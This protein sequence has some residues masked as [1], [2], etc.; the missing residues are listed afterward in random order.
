MSMP[1]NGTL[2]ASRA[3]HRHPMPESVFFVNATAEAEPS[4]ASIRKK[5]RSHVMTQ[6]HKNARRLR[7]SH[8]FP[9]IGLHAAN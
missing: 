8:V 1:Q 6:Y 9:K 2:A 5:A 4:Q 3:D 7:V